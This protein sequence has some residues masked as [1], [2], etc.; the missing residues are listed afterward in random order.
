VFVPRSADASEGDGWIVSLI[1]R[2]A[3][4][5]SDFVVLDALDIAAGPVAS[6]RIPRRVPFGFHGSWR[7][8]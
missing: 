1:H 8:A 5:V 3:E 7:V 4:D 6:A 2:R